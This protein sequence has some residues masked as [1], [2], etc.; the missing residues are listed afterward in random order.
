MID[1]LN[2]PNIYIKIA[3]EVIDKRIDKFFE[4]M[5]DIL[6]S[7]S[8]DLKLKFSKQALKDYLNTTIKKVSTVKTLLYPEKPVLINDFYVDID[9]SFKNKLI[10]S[11]RIES[12]L[13]IDKNLIVTGLAGCGKSTFIKYLF[14][15]AIE[16][17]MYIPLFIELRYLT[18]GEDLISFIFKVLE[19]LNFPPDENFFKRL[20]KKGKFIIFLDGIDEINPEMSTKFQREIFELSL[21]YDKNYFVITS[22]PNESFISWS[23]FTELKIRPLSKEKAILLIKKLNFN[24]YLKNKFISDFNHHLFKKYKSFTT[25]PLLL[26]LML[27]TYIESGSIPNKVTLL[28]DQVFETLWM[29]HDITAKPYYHRKRFTALDFE[30][31]KKVFSYFCSQ[32]YHDRKI[33]FTRSEIRDYLDKYK[34]KSNFTFDIDNYISDLVQTVC[35]LIQEGYYFTFIHRTFQEYFTA[36]YILNCNKEVRKKLYTKLCLRIPSDNVLDTIFEINRDIFEN[37][38]LIPRIE[39]TK[40]ITKFNR[41]KSNIE[42]FRIFTRIGFKIAFLN[43]PHA[44]LALDNNHK[45]KNLIEIVYRIYFKLYPIPKN[46]VQLGISYRKNFLQNKISYYKKFING[47]KVDGICIYKKEKVSISEAFRFSKSHPE[48]ILLIEL[49]TLE[50]N[51]EDLY[52]F[53]LAQI[54]NNYNQYLYLIYILETISKKQANSELV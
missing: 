31:F 14:L 12:L 52:N 2:D 36:L 17:R 49:D 11:D 6:T 27:L 35:L 43:Y 18:L 24:S 5:K 34:E 4:S 40:E 8:Y 29:R 16:N 38:F 9:L 21:K 33:R 46:I 47:E 32:S 37:E 7:R 42:S 45:T 15:N 10:S 19:G 3:S 53:C 39:A 28:Y 26:T 50:K 41:L 30:K 48:R 20:L 23:N 44:H 51:D 13:K 1:M 54:D 22:R 25:N